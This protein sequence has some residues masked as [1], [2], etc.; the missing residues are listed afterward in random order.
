LLPPP[1]W[2]CGGAM[3]RVVLLLWW[4][5]VLLPLGRCY[6]IKLFAGISSY[7]DFLIALFSTQQERQQKN[8]YLHV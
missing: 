5:L 8:I 1:P 3:V 2:W 7:F 6:E 4:W